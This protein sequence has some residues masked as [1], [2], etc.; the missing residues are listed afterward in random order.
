MK[1]SL[2]AIT[3]CLLLAGLHA[4]FA[5]AD[6]SDSKPK[7]V[8]LDRIIAVVNDDVITQNELKKQVR[9][10]KDRLSRQ[11]TQLPPENVLRR[12]VLEHMVVNHLQLQVAKRLG[13][14]VD[15]DQLNQVLNNIARQNQLTLTQFRALLQKEGYDFA[16]FREDIRHQMIISR[17]HKRQIDDKVT[18]TDQEVDDFLANKAANKGME[19]EYHLAHILISLPEA[20][21]PAQIQAAQAKAQKVLDELRNGA[22]FSQTAIAVSSG[23]QALKGGDLGWRKA[24]QLPTPFADVVTKMQVGD[25][26]GLIRSPSGFHIIKLLDKRSGSKHIVKQTLARHILIR[27]NELVSNDEAR[28]RLERLRQRILNGADFGQLAR[29]NSDDKVSAANGGSLGWL[30]PGDVVPRFEEVMNGLKPGE[31]SQPFRTRFGWHIVQVMARRNYDNTKDFQRSQARELLHK[32]K[33]EEALQNWLRQLRD[34]AYV[35]YRFND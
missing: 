12:Q 3:L 7:I 20:A 32:R 4:P 10:I 18:V 24:G 17:L 33:A 11:Q 8:E 5:S 26:S 27:T 2:F 13:I 34:E 35:Q 30:N 1:S 14:R 6:Q 28:Q 22:D 9:L 21:T 31:I 25:I 16:D 15:D 29:A 19:E 23:Q